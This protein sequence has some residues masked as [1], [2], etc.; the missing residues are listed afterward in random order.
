[1]YIDVQYTLHIR[2]IPLVGRT[3]YYWGI[4]KKG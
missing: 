1:M 4:V 2:S 3:E